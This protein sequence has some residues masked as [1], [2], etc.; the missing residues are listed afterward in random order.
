MSKEELRCYVQASTQEFADTRKKVVDTLSLVRVFLF[1]ISVL[2]DGDLESDSREQVWIL[3]WN[4][5]KATLI[6]QSAAQRLKEGCL[7]GEKILR[8]N[9]WS[10]HQTVIIIINTPRTS[11]APCWNPLAP[12]EG[13]TVGP[14][15]A[16]VVVRTI[17]SPNSR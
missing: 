3:P 2:Q 6:F 17:G 9:R 8:K 16:G 1:L 15:G 11:K 13:S 5:E 7:V 14:P 12:E 10:E 4:F